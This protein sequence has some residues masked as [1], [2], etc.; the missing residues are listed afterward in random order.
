MPDCSIAKNEPVRPKPVCTSSA[1]S[2]I[3]C[4]SQ[5]AR[6]PR[7]YDGGR[8]D[9]A[10]LALHGLDHDAGDLRRVDDVLNAVRSAASAS[11]EASP[12]PQWYSSGNGTR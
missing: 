1:I 4:S 9:E 8:G 5:S 6:R 10:A 7:R 11:A 3:P 2:T 12:G